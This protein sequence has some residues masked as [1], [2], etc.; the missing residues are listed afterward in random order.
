MRRSPLW[1][2]CVIRRR[3]RHDRDACTP[4]AQVADCADPRFA[5]TPSRCAVPMLLKIAKTGE[6]P[7]RIEAYK[8]LAALAGAETAGGARRDGG[9]RAVPGGG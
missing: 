2:A 9:R 4:R 7:V 3:G 6:Q 1:L 5:G 8:A